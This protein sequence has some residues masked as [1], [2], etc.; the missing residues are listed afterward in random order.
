MI[1]NAQVKRPEKIPAATHAD[2]SARI[3]T[4]S[5]EDNARYHALISAFKDITGVPVVLN[6]SFND[7]E[8]IVETPKDA[9]NTF[10]KTGIDVLCLG[11]YWVEKS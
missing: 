8:A 7:N 10:L 9:I 2:G 1:L 3:Q 5:T 4:V 11:D 6:T